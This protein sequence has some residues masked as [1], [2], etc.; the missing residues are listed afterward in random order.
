MVSAI[1]DQ[2]KMIFLYCKLSISSTVVEVNVNWVRPICSKGSMYPR[3]FF[4]S[5][6]WCILNATKTVGCTEPF[7]QIA[8]THFIYL[9]FLPN[10]EGSICKQCFYYLPRAIERPLKE[11]LN[12]KNG[13]RTSKIPQRSGGRYLCTP[14]SSARSPQMTGIHIRLIQVWNLMHLST[15]RPLAAV[16][17]RSW[18]SMLI[19]KRV[20]K[21]MLTMQTAERG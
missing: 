13:V 9:L 7:E 17:T 16:A 1:H 4:H 12:H 19:A 10:F 11:A 8:R 6:Q 20:P 14:V 15:P 3:F 21:I 2:F 18:H 5:C